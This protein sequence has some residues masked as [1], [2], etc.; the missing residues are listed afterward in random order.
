MEP[1]TTQA[2]QMNLMFKLTC[3]QISHMKKQSTYSS[4]EDLGSFG[5][6]NKIPG[7][8]ETCY[9]YQLNTLG[10]DEQHAL[11]ALLYGHNKTRL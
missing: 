9:D 5:N 8:K 4:M 7:N 11:S 10:I 3:R 1:E 2:E 6:A